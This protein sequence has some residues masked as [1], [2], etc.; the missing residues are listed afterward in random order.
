MLTRAN[1][2]ILDEPTNQL[3][4]IAKEALD[5]ALRDFTGTLITV[6][7]DRYFLNSVPTKIIEM[8]PDSLEIY[9]GNYDYYLEHRRLPNADK[10]EEKAESEQSKAY[11]ETKL[12]KAL[13]RKKRAK[14]NAL[15]KEIQTLEEEIASLKELSASQ[16]VVSDYQK[17]SEILSQIEEKEKALAEKE[18]EWLEISE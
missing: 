11:T 15:E 4:Y 9:N 14:I 12:N 2:L 13:E 3:D 18:T 10:K 17:L 8:F 16:E 5:T 6:S 7:H 1:V